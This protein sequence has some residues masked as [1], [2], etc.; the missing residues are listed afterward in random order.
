MV[1]L[2]CALGA[3]QSVKLEALEPPGAQRGTS[4]AIELRGKALA[5]AEALV[6][7]HPGLSASEVES[8]KAGLVRARLV[9]AP[10][11]PLGPYT[12]RV[13]TRRG[14]SNALMFHV[15]AL[16]TVDEIEPNGER[17]SAQTLALGVTVH[18]TITRED[19]DLFAFKAPPGT[20]VRAVVE[21][22]RLGCRNFDPLVEVLDAEGTTLARNDDS[23]LVRRDSIVEATMPAGGL[24]LVRVRDAAR[25][26]ARDARYRLH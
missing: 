17:A 15:G 11:A 6:F 4:V 26:G 10:D 21:A 12:V 18:G 7:D 20:R 5:G 3:A 25:G 16:V 8:E 13:R 19:E 1:F 2:L 23:A 9:V 24:C 22:L 14:L